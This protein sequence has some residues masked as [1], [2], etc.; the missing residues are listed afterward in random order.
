MHSLVEHDQTAEQVRDTYVRDSHGEE[1]DH[2][3]RRQVEQ[4]KGHD[5]FPERRDFGIETGQPVYN[6]TEDERGDHSEGKKIKEDLRDK[7]NERRVITV[8]PDEVSQTKFQGRPR[9]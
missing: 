5:E 2:T 9:M 6:G 7:I 3:R 8:C 4:D 1:Q